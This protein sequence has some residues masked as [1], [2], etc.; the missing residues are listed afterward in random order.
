M[1]AQNEHGRGGLSTQDEVAEV[2]AFFSTSVF[3]E[4]VAVPFKGTRRGAER[5]PPVDRELM[6]TW[7]RLALWNSR[8][9]PNQLDRR[10]KRQRKGII[11]FGLS[12]EFQ[13]PP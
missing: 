6:T 3:V 4:L 7:S 9:L 5:S 11:S 12:V 2:G 8:Q 1:C 13:S 10:L